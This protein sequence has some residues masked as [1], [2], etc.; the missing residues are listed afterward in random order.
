VQDPVSDKERANFCDN[1]K[2]RREWGSVKSKPD[3]KIKAAKSAF[4]ALFS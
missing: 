4:D 2:V 3:E 1:F